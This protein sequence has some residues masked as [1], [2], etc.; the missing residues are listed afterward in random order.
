[1]FPARLA[2]EISAAVAE[3]V[4]AG[5]G[6]AAPSEVSVRTDVDRTC[7]PIERPARPHRGDFSSPVALRWSSGTSAARRLAELLATTVQAIDGVA[8][9]EVA[10]DGYLNVRIDAAALARIARGVIVAGPEYGVERAYDVVASRAGHG[11]ASTRAAGL[12]SRLGHEVRWAHVRLVAA[13][14]AGASL[15]VWS[16]AWG[17]SDLTDLVDEVL[18]ADDTRRLLCALAEYPTA[19][20]RG[21]GGRAFRRYLTELVA[22]VASFEQAGA[23]V[24]QGIDEPNVLHRT[25]LVVADAS[26]TVIANALRCCGEEPPIRM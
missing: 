17:G 25:R 22:L 5:A 16:G 26:R 23:L 12:V 13:L 14:R 1:M 20:R 24:P 2:D 3:L 21:S 8:C 10:G 4:D 18:A 11:A 7:V 6:S 19:V 9:C 15:G